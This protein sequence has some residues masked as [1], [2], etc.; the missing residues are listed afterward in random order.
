[1]IIDEYFMNPFSVMDQIKNNEKNINIS[2]QNHKN[3]SKRS[4]EYRMSLLTV[5]CNDVIVIRKHFL[6]LF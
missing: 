5:N 6:L 4:P 2:L 3:Q 1:M